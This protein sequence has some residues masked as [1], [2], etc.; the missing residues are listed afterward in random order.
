MSATRWGR[1]WADFDDEDETPL[2]GDAGRFETQADKDG[3]K[4]VIEYVEK[5]GSTYKI[6]KKVKEVITTKWTNESIQARKSLE[7][8]GKAATNTEADEKT[9]CMRCIDETLVESAK[10]IHVDLSQKDDA[11][12]KFFEESLTITDSLLKEKKVWTDLNKEMKDEVGVGTEDPPAS[13]L[14]AKAK[15]S[16]PVGSTAPGKYVP[17][18]LR[19]EK[20]GGDSKG[21]GKGKGKSKSKGKGKDGKGKPRRK[22]MGK[23]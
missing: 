7:K 6:T 23:A 18:S 10:K 17:P 9:L 3:I 2:Q 20:G 15:D 5:N 14:G 19:G 22:G 11:E 8:F 16:E 1:K 21:K 13:G 12:E 4:S